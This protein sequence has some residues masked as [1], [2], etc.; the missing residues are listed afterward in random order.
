ME[1]TKNQ[2][3]PVIKQMMQYPKIV[4]ELCNKQQEAHKIFKN[5]EQLILEHF[6]R[7]KRYSNEITQRKGKSFEGT[8]EEQERILTNVSELAYIGY[9]ANKIKE[10]D[11]LLAKSPGINRSMLIDEYV[12][13]YI[14]DEIRAKF[15]RDHEI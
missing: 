2:L 10:I 15:E 7:I 13:E 8:K 4:N 1:F 14:K 6:E 3:I 11:D 9:I 5:L 12:E